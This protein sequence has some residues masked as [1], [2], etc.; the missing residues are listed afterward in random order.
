VISNNICPSTV[1]IDEMP[2]DILTDPNGGKFAAP[3]VKRGILPEMLDELLQKRLEVKKRMKSTTDQKEKDLLDAI[4]YSYKILLN[5]AYGYTGYKRSRLFNLIVAGAVT[6]YGRETIRGVRDAVE[7]KF[8]GLVV[9]EKSFSLHVVA[10]DTDSCFIKMTSNSEITKEDAEKVGSIVT[11][12][13]SEPMPYPKKL[14]YEGYVRRGI[15]LAKKRYAFWV[16]ERAGNGEWKDKMK[17]MGIETVRRDWCPLT[18]ETMK[19]CLDLILKEGNI[20]AAKVCAKESIKAVRKMKGYD[21]QLLLKLTLTRKYSKSAENYKTKAHGHAQL[22]ERMK[23]R[24]DVAPMLGDRIPYLVVVGKTWRGGESRQGV[25][26][27]AED[28][29]HIVKNGLSI[30]KEYYVKKQLLKPLL[31]LLKPFGITEVEMD[32]QGQKYLLEF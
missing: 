5:S 12:K 32:P 9:N 3:S 24:G 11:K 23:N 7:N 17:I 10:G 25:S 31:R 2:V 6:A 14:N 4:Q 13:I 21:S 20:E 16:F 22:A 29:D 1:V 28:L 19:K 27:R 18:A 30:D 26:E 8:D 15:I